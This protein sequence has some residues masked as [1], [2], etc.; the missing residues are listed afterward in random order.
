M[1]DALWRWSEVPL[2]DIHGVIVLVHGLGEHS[3]RYNELV[4]WLV[5]YEYAVLGYDQYGHGRSPG[6]CAALMSDMQLVRDLDN[7][8]SE[9]KKCFKGVPVYLLGHSVGGLV[10]LDY[11]LAHPND[12]AGVIAL[13]PALKVHSE[14][15]GL[16]LPLILKVAPNF[17]VNNSLPISGISRDSHVVTAY[18]QDELVHAKIT[19]RLAHYILMAGKRVRSYA[20]SWQVPTLLLYAAD[21]QLVDS[22]GSVE[23]SKEAPLHVLTVKCFERA[24][25]ELHHEPDTSEFYRALENWLPGKYC[26]EDDDSLEKRKI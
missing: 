26:R 4:S 13:S 3:K 21:D 6:R 8:V 12:V 22:R 17:A 5:M 2:G 14:M 10:V 16:I 19:P 20:Q 1:T 7:I 23:F 11:V 24:Y 15:R 9:V 18:K 25:H